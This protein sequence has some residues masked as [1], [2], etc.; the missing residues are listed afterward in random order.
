MRAAR[1]DSL[2]I[3]SR[4]RR[5]G[6]SSGAL[7]EPFGPAE[8][9]RERVVQFV[10]DAGD[11]LPERRHLLRLQQLVID[12]ARFVVQL[13][14]FADVADE[15]LDAQAAVLGRRIGARGQL[16]P[17]RVAVGAAQAQQIV[18]DRAVGGEPFEQRDAGLG[19]DEA[20]GVERPDVALRRFAVVAEN[21]LEVGIGGDASSSSRDRWSR[22]RRL[23][24]PPRT[25]AQTPR[26]ALHAGI[27]RSLA[28]RAQ[29]CS[30][31]AVGVGV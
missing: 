22:C 29:G 4:P 17:D 9:R 18:V 2:R 10:R 3:V 31:A 25:A 14:A 21:Q 26:P 19:I 6:S 15:R 12:V 5:T 30:S 7:R 8:D 16:H 1:S 28:V 13:L 23:R 11:R 20:I 27:I 24:A